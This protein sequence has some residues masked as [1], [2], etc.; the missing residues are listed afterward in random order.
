MICVLPLGAGQHVGR[1]CL[2]L[3]VDGRRILL[4]CGIHPG[5]SGSGRFPD[6]SLMQAPGAA[7]ANP[8]D[9][10]DAVL[11]SHFHLD[12]IG[13]LPYLT[14][15]LGYRGP[16]VMT[17]PTKA[18]APMLLRDY[19]KVS[20]E[21][22]RTGAGTAAP[23]SNAQVEACMQRVTGVSLHQTIHVGGVEV[24]TYYAGHVLGAV[25]FH[26]R[27]GE[28]TVVY[29]GDFSSVADH[30]L[31]AASLPRVRP[32]LLI[33][34][35]T[36]A[37]ASRT[38]KRSR[39]QEFLEGIRQCVTAGGKV[40]IPVFAVGRAQEVCLL[41]NTYWEQTGLGGR[42][43]IF[44]AQGLAEQATAFY[45]V[46]SNWT[47]VGLGEGDARGAGTVLNAF[48]F[49]HT[50]VFRKALHWP[51]VRARGQPMV[52]FATPAMLDGG[53]ALEIFR[54]WA[55]DKR[56]LLVMTG[57]CA[58]GTIGHAV[59]TGQ[60]KGLR[61]S[62]SVTIDVRC[63]VRNISFSAHADADGLV[64]IIRQAEPRNVLLVHGEASKLRAFRQRV[65][66]EL[67]I[68]CAAPPNGTTVRITSDQ[69][70][71]PWAEVPDPRRRRRPLS[72][73]IE[74]T[75]GPDSL[76]AEKLASGFVGPAQHTPSWMAGLAEVT[77]AMP[78]A[79]TEP[80]RQGSSLTCELRWALDNPMANAETKAAVFEVVGAKRQRE[81]DA[82]PQELRG[83]SKAGEAPNVITTAAAVMA[84]VVDA[85]RK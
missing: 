7:G 22:N 34:E 43:P 44:F 21:R 1:S 67:Q 57:Y 4:D 14:E 46:F 71:T 76:D 47:N 40:L 49:Q 61:L 51:A 3:T 45:K 78:C 41:L 16:V 15:I 83:A 65:A 73:R 8:A 30:H 29:T 31:R 25:M 75:E 5:L 2:L 17:H 18:I 81:A 19:R 11:I 58:A 38:W 74:T 39:E 54:E 35:G 55:D 42:V 56:N 10:I 77:A 84:E 60:R 63:A 82:I 62:A 13:A 69:S 64:S 70:G 6:F 72:R 33:S 27:A 32:T 53:L 12:H 20:A 24:S 79:A 37:T 66:R 26:I 36:Y 28:Q 85:F 59:V 52:I 68:P 48:D 80:Q 9:S 23:F 50:S